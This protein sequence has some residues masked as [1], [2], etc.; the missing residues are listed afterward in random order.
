MRWR[1]LLASAALS[2][3]PLV[4]R[5]DD[6]EAIEAMRRGVAAFGRGDAE[7]AL[8]EYETAKQAAPL[9]NAPYR[10][11]AEALVALRRYR[12]AVDNL[13]GYLAK[14]PDVSDAEE[15]RLE[16]A[17]IRAEHFPARA[18][19]ESNVVGAEVLVD[20]D[21]RG[22]IS[23][24]EVAPGKHIIDLRASGHEQA[25]RVVTLVGDQET[26]L[27]FVLSPIHTPDPPE[28][29]SGMPWRT[30]GWG[31]AGVGAATLVTSIVVDLAV[32]GPKVTAYRDAADRGD[33]AARGLRDDARSLQ[34]L[35]LAG[36]VASGVLLVGGITLVLVAPGGRRV[37]VSASA[38]GAVAI[39]RF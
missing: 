26:T 18:R 5:A 39:A 22:A 8:R 11:A 36:Y 23:T 21:S 7:E 4:A 35:T 19:I 14:K 38:G 9:A 32:L 20:G 24:L 6:A 30:V 25:S 37:T 28:E 16:I 1:V 3:A 17:R 29:P 13:E 10:Y 27:T 34:T 12:D 2:L 33:P 15:V 31:I